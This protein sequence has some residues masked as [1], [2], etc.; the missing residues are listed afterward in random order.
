MCEQKIVF[1]QLWHHCGR[2]RR[3]PCATKDPVARAQQVLTRERQ[4][5]EGSCKAQTRSL[6]WS[7]DARPGLLVDSL[8]AAL[9]P[10]VRATVAENETHPSLSCTTN[11]PELQR[12]MATLSKMVWLSFP[13]GQAQQPDRAWLGATKRDVRGEKQ[14]KD[15]I[16]ATAPW[17][18]MKPQSTHRAE[19]I[20]WIPA[21]STVPE[22][23]MSLLQHSTVSRPHFSYSSS[24]RHVVW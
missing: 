24:R 12:S 22:C 14:K 8:L 10:F 20:L 3:R 1:S 9:L 15:C 16:R 19:I 18:S 21:R 23:N 2:R 13:L 4:R 17:S 7:S 5:L 6:R 11:Q